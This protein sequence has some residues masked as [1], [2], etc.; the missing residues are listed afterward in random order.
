VPSDEIE[1]LPDRFDRDGR[2]LDGSGRES[3]MVERIAKGVGEVLE[4]RG[5]WKDLLR[6]LLDE[7]GGRRR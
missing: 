2:P 3:E 6:G 1:V 4:G 7:G 5:S